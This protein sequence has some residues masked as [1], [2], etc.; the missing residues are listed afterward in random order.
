MT[1][2]MEV[3]ANEDIREPLPGKPMLIE[4]FAHFGITPNQSTW[5]RYRLIAALMSQHPENQFRIPPGGCKSTNW[6]QGVGDCTAGAIDCA[7]VEDLIGSVEGKRARNRGPTKIAGRTPGQ[8][9]R[10]LQQ[11]SDPAT[12]TLDW[13]ALLRKFGRPGRQ[14][15]H[16]YDRPNRRFPSRIGDVPGTARRRARE[17]NKLLAVVDTSAS[18]T[19]SVVSDVF[20]ELKHLQ[21]TADV[22]V[23]ECDAAVQRVYSIVDSPGTFKGR[24]GTDLRPPF[25]QEFLKKHEPDA[26]VY[27]TDGAGPFSSH[28]PGIPTLWVLVGDE[29]FQCP[30]GRQV[31]MSGRHP[32]SSSPLS[33]GIGKIGD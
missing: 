4:A 30:W 18:M 6:D 8:L 28:D 33:P 23:V 2:A 21:E 22:T 27:F 9:L 26:V 19:E 16:S 11:V 14:R 10:S 7:A 17:R 32:V 12:G 15:L 25:E 1:I 31:R 24:G 29:P 20:A 13:K 5:Q 3:S